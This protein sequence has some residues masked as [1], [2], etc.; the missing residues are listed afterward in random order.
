MNN[1]VTRQV[2]GKVMITSKGEYDS[3]KSYE[4]LDVVTYQGSSY[5]SKKYNNDSLPTN[6]NDW[7]LLAQK[8]ELTN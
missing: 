3:S 6:T 1:T 5:L 2:L 8:G 7:Q 4:I